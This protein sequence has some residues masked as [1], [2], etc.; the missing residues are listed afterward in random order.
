METHPIVS[1]C[2]TLA[3]TLWDVRDM[4]PLVASKNGDEVVIVTCC[5]NMISFNPRTGVMKNTLFYQEKMKLW[6]L[7]FRVIWQLLI[8]RDL[9]HQIDSVWHAKKMVHTNIWILLLCYCLFL[10]K[11]KKY[12]CKGFFGMQQLDI[13]SFK[14][15]RCLKC[16]NSQ[17]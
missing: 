14:F 8:K 12:I 2:V 5:N 11:R 10:C 4:T 6:C 13:W 15:Q 3:P 1:F 9:F 7:V 16:W 17:V